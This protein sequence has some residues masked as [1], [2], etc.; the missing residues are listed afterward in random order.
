MLV[1]SVECGK[2]LLPVIDAEFENA[3]DINVAARVEIDGSDDVAILEGLQQLKKSA[4]SKYNYT[5]YNSSNTA[6]A[7][8]ANALQWLLNYF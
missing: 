8:N 5:V 6:I 3:T 7:P 1:D 2:I 4:R